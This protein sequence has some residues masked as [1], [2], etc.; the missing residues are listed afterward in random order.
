MLCHSKAFILIVGLLFFSLS[1]FSQKLIK[2]IV[3][4]SASFANL[5]DVNVK[6][7]G[8]NRGTY[9]NASGI[10][11]IVASEKDTLIFSSIGFARTALPVYVNDETML[12]RMREESIL[13]KEITINDQG[14]H[15]NQRYTKSPTL[16][17]TKPI[18]AAAGRRPQMVA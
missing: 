8:T 5:P 9:T 12:V 11:T 3:V 15:I 6:V 2:G 4:D 18:K 1:S 14:Y 17:T 13:L 7:K 10:F 16:A